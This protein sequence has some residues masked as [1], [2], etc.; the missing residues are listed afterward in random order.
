[1]PPCV[2]AQPDDED[3][4]EDDEMDEGDDDYDESD[5]YSDDYAA[6]HGECFCPQCLAMQGLHW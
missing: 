2:L 5:G 3:F 6:H 1:M 4:D